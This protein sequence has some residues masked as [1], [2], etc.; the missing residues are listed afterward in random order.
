MPGAQILLVLNI[1]VQSITEFNEIKILQY[2]VKDLSIYLAIKTN[3]SKI[4]H[5]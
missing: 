3:R 5:Q 4:H 1:T 2:A